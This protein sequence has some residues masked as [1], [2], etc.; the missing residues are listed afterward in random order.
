MKPKLAL[1]GIASLLTVTAVIIIR[2]SPENIALSETNDTTQNV[3]SSNIAPTKPLVSAA[4]TQSPSNESIS[5][6]QPA[7]ADA[8]I[9][10]EQETTLDQ[11][12]ADNADSDLLQAFNPSI[13][14]KIFDRYQ[15]N[16]VDRRYF[17][18]QRSAINNAQAGDTLSV[19]IPH[20]EQTYY[21]AVDYIE[22]YSN[23]D[24]T[25]HGWTFSQQ[26]IRHPVTLT[27][28]AKGTFG[29]VSTP[30]AS[31]TIEVV[32]ETGW[33]APTNE[34]RNQQDFNIPDYVVPDTDTQAES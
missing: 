29:N 12:F 6:K 13:L 15:N 9:T 26:G 24:K 33:I 30:E 1:L 28:G 17:E 8:F 32:D 5:D 14:P 27:Q 23:G 10:T 21:I 11:V 31:Y 20:A 18:F 4:Q 2:L 16:S 22:T 34:I 19:Y 7:N 25:L 3:E